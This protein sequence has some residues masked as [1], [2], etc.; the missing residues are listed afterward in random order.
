MKDERARAEPA[1]EAAEAAGAAGVGEVAARPS[2]PSRRG[3][4]GA[5]Q[6]ARAERATAVV[7]R[8]SCDR[9][10][11]V[12]HGARGVHRAEAAGADGPSRSPQPATPEP[13]APF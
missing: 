1:A 2:T 10:R 12:R 6:G 4:A 13:S 5:S 7:R 8:P 9:P 11:P 3:P